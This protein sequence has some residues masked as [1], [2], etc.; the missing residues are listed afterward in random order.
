MW[1]VLLRSCFQN[2]L[3]P[4]GRILAYQAGKGDQEF[5]V[6]D[7]RKGDAFDKVYDQFVFSRRGDAVAYTALKSGK[8]IVVAGERK[9]E[10][11][12]NVYPIAF[13]AD[14]QTVAYA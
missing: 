2:H 3:V 8:A 11:F 5:A 6:I 1:D 9:G 10:E 13:S 14:G 7:G 12:E 4:E